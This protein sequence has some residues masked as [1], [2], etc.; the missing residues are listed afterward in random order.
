MIYCG[1]LSRSSKFFL[2]KIIQKK[3]PIKQSS[4][5]TIQQMG[6]PVC[7]LNCYPKDFLATRRSNRINEIRNIRFR[8]LLNVAVGGCPSN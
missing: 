2:S 4:L 6:L 3:D 1:V 5:E 7:Y 8:V